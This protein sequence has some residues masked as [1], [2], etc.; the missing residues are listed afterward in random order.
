MIP[1]EGLDQRL[2]IVFGRVE[3]A[4]KAIDET[5][6]KD[7]EIRRRTNSEVP[8]SPDEIP[9]TRHHASSRTKPLDCMDTGG[10]TEVDRRNQRGNKATK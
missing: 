8:R 1:P 2:Q 7:N 4:R 9:H 6:E 10:D 5:L 3:A